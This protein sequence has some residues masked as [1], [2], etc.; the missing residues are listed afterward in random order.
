MTKFFI[1]YQWFGFANLAAS[2]PRNTFVLDD[3]QRYVPQS[4]ICRVA[5]GA[6][7]YCSLTIIN[8]IFKKFV[9]ESL[10]SNKLNE[11]VDLCSVCNVSKTTLQTYPYLLEIN[12]FYNNLK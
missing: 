12:A 5:V 7:V 10:V 9:Y 11:F 6:L 4:R 8:I 2:D 1:I 3:Y